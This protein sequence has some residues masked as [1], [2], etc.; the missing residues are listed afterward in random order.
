MLR[1]H[2]DNRGGLILVLIISL[3]FLLQLTAEVVAKGKKKPTPADPEMI[4]QPEETKEAWQVEPKELKELQ[5]DPGK[6]Y[7]RMKEAMEHPSMSDIMRDKMKDIDWEWQLRK[8]EKIT[9]EWEYMAKCFKDPRYIWA[10]HRLSE[11]NRQ[12]QRL[13]LGVGGPTR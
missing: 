12:A 8:Q 11:L 13:L 2:K 10:E 4:V 9:L 5:G 1:D 6:V 7:L 3:I